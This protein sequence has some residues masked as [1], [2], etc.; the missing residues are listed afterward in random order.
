MV[1]PL[2]RIPERQY[3][4]A[5]DE[6]LTDPRLRLPVPPIDADD[7]RQQSDDLPPGFGGVNRSNGFTPHPATEPAFTTMT[8]RVAPDPWYRTNAAKL[9]IVVLGLTVAAAS[10]VVLL[11]P[12][13]TSGPPTEDTGVSTPAPSPS[14]APTETAPSSAPP[15][16]PD[17]A[18]PVG[19]PPGAPPPPP[20]DSADQMAPPSAPARYYPPQYDEP[21]QKK[22]EIDVTRAPISVAPTV[23]QQPPSNSATPGDGPRRRRG[24]F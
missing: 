21:T 12:N 16:P 23:T 2:D 22:P 18:P 10:L 3:S 15:L 19:L 1:R 5:D 9:V 17:L 24:F 6:A 4:R 20:P 14:A 13:S 11:W 8:F 7:V